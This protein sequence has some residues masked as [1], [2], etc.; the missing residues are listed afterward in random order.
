MNKP[1]SM[2]RGFEAEV[3]ITNGVCLQKLLADSIVVLTVYL[4]LV[5][6]HSQIYYPIVLPQVT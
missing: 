4:V 2:V 6:A 1:F 3:I 5:I